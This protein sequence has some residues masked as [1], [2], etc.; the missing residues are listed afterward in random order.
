MILLE[1]ANLEKRFGGVK[2]VKDCDFTVES[3]TITGLIGPNGAGKTT[4]FNMITGLVRP[5][6]GT[7][8]FKGEP[9]TGMSPHD[10][11]D[12]GISRTFQ[13]LRIF[14]KLTALENLMLA[15]PG[16][17][18]MMFDRVFRPRIVK[19]EEAAKRKRAEEYLGLV[20][21]AEK[22]EF[23]AGDLSY[24]QQKLLD[25]ARCL[26]SE[27]DLILLDEPVAGVN[28]V[29][30]NKI[31]GLLRELRRQGRTV[32]LIEHDMNFVMDLC[33]KVV[34][35]DHGEEIAIGPPKKIKNDK[36]VIK[37]YLG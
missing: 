13:M 2:A 33:D 16:K 20:G 21:L 10:I 6:G 30:R 14:P 31:K 25:I 19:E 8:V 4:V 32:L 17:A 9:L 5:D 15:H 1:V 35:L 29:L 28:P 37:A 34:V 12:L 26:A 7:I 11:F 24:G 22:K 23:K 18:E 36:K 3:D 27:A